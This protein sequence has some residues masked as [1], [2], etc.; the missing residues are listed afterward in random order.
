MAEEKEKPRED[1]LLVADVRATFLNGDTIELLPF[2]NEEDVRS[3]INKFIEDWVKTGFLLKEN[4]LY[5]WHQVKSVEVVSVQAM[6]HAQAEP[7]LEVWQR[8]AEG[9]KLFWKTRKPQGKGGDKKDDAKSSPPPG[10]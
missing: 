1:V 9:Q 7:Y 4:F 6:T 10:H 3:E 8:D 2:K 5:P